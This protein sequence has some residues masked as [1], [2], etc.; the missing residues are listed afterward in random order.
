MLLEALTASHTPVVVAVKPYAN[1]NLSF[2][3][4]LDRSLSFLP[5]HTVLES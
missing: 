4:P 5:S 3:S 2:L 1:A